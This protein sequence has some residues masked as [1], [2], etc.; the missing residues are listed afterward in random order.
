MWLEAAIGQLTS[1]QLIT[2]G[3]QP[4]SWQQ[5]GNQTA[6]DKA[7]K[8]RLKKQ[9]RACTAKA[10]AEAKRE[11]R[12]LKQVEALQAEV[13]H[14]ERVEKK[15]LEQ[16]EA[17]KAREALA[18]RTAEKKAAAIAAAVAAATRLKIADQELRVAT[19]ARS[20]LD[21]THR[22][23][24]DALD[25]LDGPIS[26]SEQADSDSDDGAP[27]A[28]DSESYGSAP[29]VSDFDGFRDPIE[30]YSFVGF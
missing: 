11:E 6:T 22:E 18:V 14:A 12:R 1:G 26:E 8:A 25:K 3:Q 17:Q 24:L 4:A 23:A 27:V 2:Y 19:E 16:V 7:E 29:E 15:L 9:H 28:S 21:E 10:N 5:P 20:A 13:E 30:H